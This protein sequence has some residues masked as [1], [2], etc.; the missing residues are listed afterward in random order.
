MAYERISD[1]LLDYAP[2]RYGTSKLVFRGPRQNVD[3]DFIAFLGGNETYGKF[4]ERPF[5]E[6]VGAQLRLPTVNLGCGNAG[7]DVYS[8]DPTV[9]ELSRRARLRVV[10]IPGAQNL[11][12]RMYTVHPRRNDRFVRASRLLTV[13]YPE[14]DFTEVHFTGHLLRA[15]NERCPERFEL[16]T[17][18]LRNAWTARMTRFLQRIGGP[19]LLLW[20]SRR[21]PDAL[22]QVLSVEPRLVTE[23]MLAALQPLASGIVKVVTPPAGAQAGAEGMVFSELE[24]PAA[25]DLPGPSAHQVIA[26]RV[27]A[28]LE[29]I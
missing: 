23:D 9:L 21:A 10:Q 26:E 28:A 24:R 8:D 22:D 20:V 17:D 25:V 7:V 1:G 4:I 18:E 16:V 29:A 27:V 2:C 14:I 15:L 12:N 11:S 19:T 6:I 13:L 5:P 3:G